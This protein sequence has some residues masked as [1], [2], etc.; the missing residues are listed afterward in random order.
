MIGKMKI[1]IL[2]LFTLGCMA[3]SLAVPDS[4]KA[5]QE[6]V[7]IVI[8][9][10]GT[11]DQ[12]MTAFIKRSLKE[13]SKYPERII[14]LELDTYGGEVDAAFQIVDTMVNIRDA[15]TIA[16][17]KTKAISAGA[18]IA[19]SCQKLVMKSNT[20]IGDVAPLTNGTDGPK[21]LGEKFQ[22]PIRAKFRTLAKQNGYPEK[23]TEAMVT[24]GLVIYEVQFPDTTLYMD[25]TE[26]AEL[27]AE[28]KKKVIS[29]KTVDKGDQLLTMDDTE[30][31]RLGFS[32]MSVESFDD[33]ISKL[34]LQKLKVIRMEESWSEA[35]VRFIGSIAPFLVMI[36]F[37]ALYMEL[38]SPGFGLPG[39]IGISCL[40]I[41]FLSQ[42]LVGLADYTEL[43]IMLI[44]VS[45]L[46]VEIFVLPG[47]GIIGI[48]GIILMII[49]IILSFQNFVIPSPELPWQAKE[50][51]NNSLKVLGSLI[52]SFILFALFF[53]Y[54]FPHLNVV[55]KGPY[56]DATLQDAK[57]VTEDQIKIVAGSKGVAESILRPAGKALF[58]DE[59]YD[60]VTEGE[61]IEKGSAI[62]VLAIQGNRIVVAKS[63]EV[64]S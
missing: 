31:K 5:E 30:A 19:L 12:G 15:Q 47:F 40:A 54:V 42:F 13:S 1:I 21:M 6:P 56:L 29:K 51:V 8:P 62:E 16:Y 17:V 23:L 20:T 34:G 60:V 46:F 57:S 7:V 26:F 45:L 4:L 36:G 3:D 58:S 33:M 41:V 2:S 11:V 63:E 61:F 44:G 59:L 9:V 55:V 37:A 48:A 25:S 24:E 49:G 39:I 50:L 43:I 38:K 14:V 52:G 27:K 35:M 10:S 64:Q 18:L 32:R 28:T 53:R 22:S